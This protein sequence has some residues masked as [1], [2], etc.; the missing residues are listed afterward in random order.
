MQ[1]E[2]IIITKSVSNID[3][4]L[5]RHSLISFPT[6]SIEIIFPLLFE[7]TIRQGKNKIQLSIWIKTIKA[8]FL[9]TPLHQ[10]RYV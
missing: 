10:K 3:I 7:I 2:I 5:R 4:A 1:D 6:L 9:V 8:S